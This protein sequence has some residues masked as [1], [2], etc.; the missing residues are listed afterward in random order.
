MEAMLAALV[1]GEQVDWPFTGAAA[2]RQFLDAAREHGV[3]P[4]VAR[5]QRRL[6]SLNNWPAALREAIA[7]RARQHAIVE[8]LHRAELTAVVGELTSRGVRPI[9]LK[10]A[11]LA[12]THYPYPCLRPRED[13]DLLVSESQRHDAVEALRARAYAPLE[14]VTGRLVTSQQTFARDAGR[15]VRHTCDL[16][17]QVSN[18]AAFSRLLPWERLAANDPPDS[19]ARRRWTHPAACAPDG[20]PASGGAPLRSADPHL[21]VRHSSAR[22]LDERRGGGPFCGA[23]GGRAAW[24]RSALVASRWHS[25]ISERRCRRRSSNSFRQATSRWPPSWTRSFGPS[26]SWCPISARCAGIAPAASCCVNT[27]F[28]RP[29]TCAR[30]GRGWA[31]DRCPGCT[32]AGS[33]AARRAGFSQRRIQIGARYQDDRHANHNRLA[34]RRTPERLGSLHGVDARAPS[35]G[36][37]RSISRDRHE[38]A[39]DDSGRRGRDRRRPRPGMHSPWAMFCCAASA[40]VRRLTAWWRCSRPITGGRCSTCAG[41]IL[42][43]LIA[44]FEP[45]TS[46]AGC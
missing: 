31:R 21:A 14:M 43:R 39:S 12:Y 18:R 24:R 45:R 36:L 41:T 3:L 29:T 11:A 30:P 19:R 34:S 4:L 8:Q 23:G 13:F 10:G 38:H 7:T 15:G 28:H 32:R 6:G 42:A 2:E 9:V 17:W 26:T 33:F 20:V 1:R 46:S 5:Q 44:R 27:S 37:Q 16:H 40:G 22:L 35:A 25:I